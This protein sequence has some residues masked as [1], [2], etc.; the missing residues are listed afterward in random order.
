VSLPRHLRTVFLP[1]HPC[2][3]EQIGAA[4][5]AQVIIAESAADQ[6]VA[7]ATADRVIAKRRPGWCR[8]DRAGDLVVAEPA[9]IVTPPP[10]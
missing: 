10:V 3:N 9:R 8:P 5:A 4:A 2:C 1:R 6:V 7:V